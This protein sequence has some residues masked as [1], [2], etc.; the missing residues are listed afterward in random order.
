[1][2]KHLLLSG[3]ATAQTVLLEGGVGN[4][5]RLIR[6]RLVPPKSCA[7]TNRT[8]AAASL[9]PDLPIF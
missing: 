1:M 3:I 8:R 9:P 7:A 5:R 4:S 6:F 2:S